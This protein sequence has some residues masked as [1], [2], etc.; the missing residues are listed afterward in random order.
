MRA[1]Q[2]MQDTHDRLLNWARWSRSGKGGP[3]TC[4]SAEGRYRPER[5]TEAEE[6]ERRSASP[7]DARDALLVLRAITPANGFPVRFYLALSAE[8]IW[9]LQVPQWQGFMRRHGQS[10]QARD[11]EALVADARIAAKNAIRRR[12]VA[13]FAGSEYSVTTADK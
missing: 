2:M 10:V 5:L 8:Y 13:Y 6:A 7:I 4:F 3:A 9:R 12:E 11:I 1:I